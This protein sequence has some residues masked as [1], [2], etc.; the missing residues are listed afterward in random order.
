MCQ[1]LKE[2]AGSQEQNQQS[3]GQ[4]RKRQLSADKSI[5]GPHPDE[6]ATLNEQVLSILSPDAGIGSSEP[7]HPPVPDASFLLSVQVIGQTLDI[8]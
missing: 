3:G 5:E 7:S 6:L 8:S 1:S 4:R 2:L